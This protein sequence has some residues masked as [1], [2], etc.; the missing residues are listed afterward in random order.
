M[1]LIKLLT[2]KNGGQLIHWYHHPNEQPDKYARSSS[3]SGIEHLGSKPVYT[4]T[5]IYMALLPRCKMLDYGLQ[6]AKHTLCLVVSY[7]Q[8]ISN[9]GPIDVMMPAM[10]YLSTK[11]T[12]SSCP[13]VLS[14]LPKELTFLREPRPHHLL[15]EPRGEEGREPAG[16]EPLEPHVVLNDRPSVR[17]DSRPEAAR[18]R[19][20]P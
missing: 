18:W 8:A 6:L 14:R 19:M 4:Y 16:R 20:K 11:V 15:G 2:G 7:Q 10:L 13:A 3:Q 1:C 17:S 12:S 5:L 9:H